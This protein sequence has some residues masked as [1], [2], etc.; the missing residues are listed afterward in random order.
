MLELSADNG[1]QGPR[2]EGS[3]SE[4]RIVRGQSSPSGVRSLL[5]NGSTVESERIACLRVAG[6]E[7]GRVM[8]WM[9]LSLTASRCAKL[10]VFRPKRMEGG[11]H[12]GR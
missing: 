7:I 8:E 12:E 3:A 1:Q 11:I 6:S 9:P 4:N 10:G 2:T 5:D